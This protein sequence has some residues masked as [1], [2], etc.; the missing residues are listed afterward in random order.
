MMVHLDTHCL[1]NH[2][3]RRVL[4]NRVRQ[5]QEEAYSILTP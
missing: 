3:I 4:Q 1:D 5:K 2:N